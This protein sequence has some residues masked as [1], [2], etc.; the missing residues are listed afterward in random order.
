VIAPL[1]ETVPILK[2]AH[3]TALVVWC[4][5]LLALPLMLS[6]HDPGISA[7]EYRRIRRSSHLTYTM[8]VT[9]AA[10]VAVIVGTWLVFLREV[11]APWM[12]LKLACVALL[13]VAHAWI[14]HILVRVAEAPEDETPPPAAA[15][16]GAVVVPAVAIL[17][18]VLGKPPLD[19][20]AFPDWLT[21][22]RGGQLPFDVPSR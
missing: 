1:V 3:I 21:A 17:V 7:G 20:I 6:R 4:G 12:Y 8:C 19:G 13:V 18:L 11:F 2:A 9:P 14:G 16:I 15:Q 22:P 10:V 5:G